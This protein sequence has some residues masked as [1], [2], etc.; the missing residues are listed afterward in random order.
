MQVLN[1]GSMCP[2]IGAASA[3]YTRGS[4]EEGLGV[5]ISRIGGISSPIFL[6]SIPSL[7]SLTSNLRRECAIGRLARQVGTRLP[8]NFNFPAPPPKPQPPF[9][10]FGWVNALRGRNRRNPC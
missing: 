8:E 4:I 5:I 9:C 10:P 2:T 3:R 6:C 1:H 7:I